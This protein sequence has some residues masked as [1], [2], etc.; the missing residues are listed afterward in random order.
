MEVFDWFRVPGPRWYRPD[1]AQNAAK[2]LRAPRP[3][4]H[5]A[6]AVS[7]LRHAV[8]NDHAG[9]LHPAAVPATTVFLEVIADHPGP[10]RMEALNVLLDWWGR[11]MADPDFATYDDPEHGPLDVCQGIS[12]KVRAAESVLREVAEDPSE[13]GHHRPA[14]KKLLRRLEDGWTNDD[15]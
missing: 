13:G 2:A 1:D 10:A 15:D 5:A 4:E 3:A 12:E 14:A 8:S 7:G 6:A 9:A 11:F